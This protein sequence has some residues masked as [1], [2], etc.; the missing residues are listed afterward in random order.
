MRCLQEYGREEEI[1][2][3]L[4]WRERLIRAPA[5]EDEEEQLAGCTLKTTVVVIFASSQRP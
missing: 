1:L 3:I 2:A 4:L 5:V